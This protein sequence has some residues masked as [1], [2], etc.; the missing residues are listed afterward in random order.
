MKIIVDKYFNSL[1]DENL[2]KRSQDELIEIIHVLTDA[3]RLSCSVNLP[4][5]AKT[6]IARDEFIECR[7][8]TFVNSAEMQHNHQISID[9]LNIE[10]VDNEN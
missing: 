4:K 9:E 1:T 5:S 8:I 10:E 6:I 7:M 2:A 3:L